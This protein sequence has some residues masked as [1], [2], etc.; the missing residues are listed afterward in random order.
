M[1]RLRRSV[2]AL[3]LIAGLLVGVVGPASALSPPLQSVKHSLRRFHSVSYAQNHGFALVV[4]VNGVS[5]IDG[6]KREGNM[7]YHYANGGLLTDGRIE[8]YHPE[9]VLYER[10]A[11]GLE[12]TAIEYIVL[13]AD[14]QLHHQ[15]PPMLYGQQFMLV[16]APNRFG[17]PD[18]YMLHAWLWK[19]NPNGRFN[20][21]NPRIPC[22]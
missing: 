13:K 11:H 1:S 8:K 3:A 2:A 6:P 9:A 17:L 21:W 22:P 15:H 5:C 14:W 10:T 19:G 16:K 7:G 4:D 12:L 20:Q 18:F